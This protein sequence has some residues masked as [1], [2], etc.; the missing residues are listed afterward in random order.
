VRLSVKRK[1]ALR[2]S[3]RE[4]RARLYWPIARGFNGYHFAAVCETFHATVSRACVRACF[5]RASFARGRKE[6]PRMA[7]V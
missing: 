3:R 6:A 7:D 4:E 1:A 5:G 2:K